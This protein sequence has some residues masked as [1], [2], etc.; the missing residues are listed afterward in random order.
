MSEVNQS[1]NGHRHSLERHE[2]PTAVEAAEH[3]A[4]AKTSPESD[5]HHHESIDSLREQVYL[6]AIETDTINIEQELADNFIDNGLVFN[7]LR[8]E[9]YQQA[10]QSIQAKLSKP[11]KIL[12]KIAHNHAVDKVS[13][14]SA[15]TVARPKSLL[16]AAGLA[17]IGSGWLL[18]IS[19]SQNYSYNL[20]IF[21][22]LLVVGYGLGLIIEL[23]LK[24]KNH[25]S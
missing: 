8:K 18:F 7:S 21:G 3:E 2:S 14:F 22:I 9:A 24:L 19:K 12:S 5:S 4:A 25:L 11:E 13:E 20:S 6:E 10:L 16:A 17:A 15:K 23:L 1:P